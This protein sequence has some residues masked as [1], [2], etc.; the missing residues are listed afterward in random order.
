MWSTIAGQTANSPQAP[1]Q[2]RNACTIA[3]MLT[4]VSACQ[5]KEKNVSKN[6]MT[7]ILTSRTGY[8]NIVSAVVHKRRNGEGDFAES[9]Q[10]G[11]PFSSM[12]ENNSECCTA[13]R[14]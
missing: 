12:E 14:V 7:K 3:T 2:L 6:Y 11:R 13:R 4:H 8:D 9:L 5:I 1:A 10:V